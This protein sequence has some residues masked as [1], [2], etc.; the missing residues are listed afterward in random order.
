[1]SVG[2]GVSCD[3]PFLWLPTLAGVSPPDILAHV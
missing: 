2:S 1:V 3:R